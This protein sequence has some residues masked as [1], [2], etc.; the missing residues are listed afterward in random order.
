MQFAI[1]L[2]LAAP[3]VDGG[4]IAAGARQCDPPLV[5]RRALPARAPAGDPEN[6]PSPTRRANQR[7]VLAVGC[8]ER[9]RLMRPVFLGAA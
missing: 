3:E 6:G 2:G 8:D 1:G 5:L 4:A 7:C 9:Q